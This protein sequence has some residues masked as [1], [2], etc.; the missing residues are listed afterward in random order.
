M[1][2]PGLPPKIR[3][4]RGAVQVDGNYL[5]GG[6]EGCCPAHY[7]VHPHCPQLV[8]RLLHLVVGD[9]EGLVLRQGVGSRFRAELQGGELGQRLLGHGHNKRQIRALRAVR[10]RNSGN[11]GKFT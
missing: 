11:W 8:G 10:K 2:A 9:G 7:I 5:G 4:A 6:V 1:C 3:V